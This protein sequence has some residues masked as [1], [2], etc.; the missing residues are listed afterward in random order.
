MPRRS[1]IP[2]D[3]DFDFAT[4]A[5]SVVERVIGEKMDGSL[6]LDKDAGKNPAAVALGRLGGAKGGA[7]RAAALSPRKRSAIAKKAAQAR[8]GK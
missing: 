6:L 2:K 5:L 7:A 3:D 4:V 1:S 8:W